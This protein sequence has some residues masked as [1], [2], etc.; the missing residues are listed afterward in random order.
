MLFSSD[1][2]ETAALVDRA[3]VMSAGRIVVELSGEAM[4]EDRLTAAAL[5][6]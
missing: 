6:G 3:Y 2:E 4:T 5:A 1:P